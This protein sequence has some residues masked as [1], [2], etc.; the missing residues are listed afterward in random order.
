MGE[1][2]SLSVFPRS[3]L[4]VPTPSL[5]AWVCVTQPHQ[6]AIDVPGKDE[7]G[8]DSGLRNG[9]GDAE[10]GVNFYYISGLR[11]SRDPGI[12]CWAISL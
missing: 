10:Y 11:I 4:S 7:E 8:L 3:R 2:F 9:S 5:T 6:G 12:A 1:L